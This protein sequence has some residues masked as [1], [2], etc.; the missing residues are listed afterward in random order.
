MRVRE[1]L[2]KVSGIRLNPKRR[3][4]LHLQDDSEVKMKLG[5]WERI[6]PREQSNCT[7]TV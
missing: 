4:L 6:V 1:Y 2:C 7:E 3:E 5:Y